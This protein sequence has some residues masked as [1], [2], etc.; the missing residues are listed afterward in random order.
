M[1]KLVGCLATAA[2]IAIGMSGN[3]EA[4]STT[5][6]G[7]IA[8]PLVPQSFYTVPAGKFFILTDMI[9]T[10]YQNVNCDVLFEGNGA[11]TSEFRIPP[12]ASL[13]VDLV[14]G[15][16]FGVGS[17]DITTDERLPGDG[18]CTPTYT[19]IGKLV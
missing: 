12:N 7:D 5:I 19:L 8:K 16:T 15:I 3:A 1:Q 4:G 9:L 10:N 17:V 6:R 11:I 18:A 14:S 13:V 2:L